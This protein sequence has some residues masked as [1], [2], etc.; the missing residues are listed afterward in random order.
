MKRLRKSISYAWQGIRLTFKEQRN[1][2]IHSVVALLVIS[3]GILL[4]ISSNEWYITIV[5]VG[6][7]LSAELLN[8]AIEKVVDLVSPEWNKKAGD[9]KDASA[10]AVLILAI[11]SAIIGCLIFGNHVIFLVR[12]EER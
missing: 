6:M 9:I 4:K 7:V 3:T 1:F 11:T 2:R 10:A 8:S 5:C 12:G